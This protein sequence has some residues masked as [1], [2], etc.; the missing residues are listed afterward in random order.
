MKKSYIQHPVTL[1]LIP[2]E[3]YFPIEQENKGPY[4]CGDIEPFQSFATS[5]RPVIGGRAQMRE[6]CKKHGLVPAQETAGLPPRPVQLPF[7][8]D[9]QGVI[10]ELKRAMDY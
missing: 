6:Y 8:R 1:E 10:N 2:A 4:V 3:E 9:R 7:K 5:D